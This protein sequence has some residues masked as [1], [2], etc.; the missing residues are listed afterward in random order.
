[1]CE[2]IGYALGVVPKTYNLSSYPIERDIQ[3]KTTKTK[4]KTESTYTLTINQSVSINCNF[5]GFLSAS[6]A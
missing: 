5:D 4:I 1:M 6:K 2:P 3:N